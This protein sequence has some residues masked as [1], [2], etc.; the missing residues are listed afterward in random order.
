LEAEGLFAVGTASIA[1][2]YDPA[3]DQVL[4]MKRIESGIPLNCGILERALGGNYVFYQTLLPNDTTLLTQVEI[5]EL[6]RGSGD[7]VPAKS[8]IISRSTPILFSNLVRW[9]ESLYAVGAQQLATATGGTRHLL[10]QLDS[11]K[12]QPQWAVRSHLPDSLNAD[13]LAE[14]LLVDKDTLVSLYASVDTSGGDPK[15]LIF[16]QKT[17]LTGTLLWVKQYDL[18]GTTHEVPIDLIQYGDGY[19]IYGA[20]DSSYF[21][22]GLDHDGNAKNSI[23][24]GN[25]TAATAAFAPFVKG[26]AYADNL[27]A[28][29]NGGFVGTDADMALLRTDGK[30]VADSC[31]FVQPIDSVAVSVVVASNKAVDLQVSPSLSVPQDTGAVFLSVILPEKL[32]CPTKLPPID[33]LDLGPDIISCKDTTVLLDAGPGYASYLWQDSST[34]Q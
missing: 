27:V 1:F 31:G 26:E 16:L 14:D 13:L 20:A 28:Y 7:V 2:R 21:L 23:R 25:G 6:Q 33:T 34:A 17:T 22:L 30:F 5:L 9:K 4:W 11:A 3:A 24:F 32:L 12:Y 15:S 29:L 18:P 19:A 8:E 10:V